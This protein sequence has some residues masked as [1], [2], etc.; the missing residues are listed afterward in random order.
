VTGAIRSVIWSRRRGGRHP[1]GLP[2]RRR[3]V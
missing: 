2:A 1:Y 3:R